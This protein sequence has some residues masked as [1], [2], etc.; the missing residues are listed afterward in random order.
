MIRVIIERFIAESLEANYEDTAKDILQKAI[1]SEGFISGESLK[2]TQNHRHRF[3]IC[4]WR[5]ITDWQKWEQSHE[6][7]EMMG[8]LNLMLEKEEKTTVLEMP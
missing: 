6:R 5:S 8:K 2:D 7:K 4:N 1:R 3:I